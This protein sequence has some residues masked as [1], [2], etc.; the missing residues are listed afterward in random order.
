MYIVQVCIYVHCTSMY[1]KDNI[2]YLKNKQV[3]ISEWKK[4]DQNL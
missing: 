1:L 4:T 2:R 3:N